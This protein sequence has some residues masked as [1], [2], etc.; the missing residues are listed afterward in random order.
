MSILVVVL[1]AAPG[2]PEREAPDLESGWRLDLVGGRELLEGS[3]KLIVFGR[4]LYWR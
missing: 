1:L 4:K 2:R 3:L